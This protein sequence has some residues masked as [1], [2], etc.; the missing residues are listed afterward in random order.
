MTRNV[1]RMARA[2]ADLPHGAALTCAHEG[3]A[4][5]MRDLAREIG[6]NDLR[7]SVV[8]WARFLGAATAVEAPR[9]S[10]TEP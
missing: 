7:V 6:R 10:A 9:L 4:E 3:S 2:L 8:D 1:G 5:Y